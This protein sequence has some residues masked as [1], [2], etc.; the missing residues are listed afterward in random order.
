MASPNRHVDMSD[1]FREN[2]WEYCKYL[3]TDPRCDHL[4]SK[5]NEHSKLATPLEEGEEEDS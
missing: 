4:L 5:S 2:V 1:D 3:I